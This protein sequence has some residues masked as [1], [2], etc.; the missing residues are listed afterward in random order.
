MGLLDNAQ[1]LSDAIEEY[2]PS[3][4]DE[5]VVRL[6][7]FDGMADPLSSDL[8]SPIAGWNDYESVSIMP[9]KMEIT[10]HYVDDDGNCYNTEEMLDGEPEWFD[11]P[12]ELPDW[13]EQ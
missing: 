10:Y 5:V 7:Q 3:K 2:G 4:N 9:P 13:Y 12:E 8:F 1:S 11:P 6:I